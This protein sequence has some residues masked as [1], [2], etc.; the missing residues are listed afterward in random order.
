MQNAKNIKQALAFTVFR[1][2]AGLVVGILLTVFLFIF[3]RGI[4]IISWEFLTAAPKEG[5]LK[6]G[7]VTAIIGTFLLIFYSALIAFPVGI[8][9]GIYMNEYLK[10][11]KVKRFIT[12]I[13][14]N[15][16]GIPSVVFGLF[17]LSIFVNTLGWGVSVISGAFT[18][19]IMILPIVIR[20]TEE[21]LK[22]VEYNF[23]LASY[24][25]G[26]TKWQT[27]WKIVLPTAMPNI[28]TGLILSVGRVAGET[29]PI[30]FTAVAYFLPTI[31]FSID[32]PVMAL[33]YHLYVL[34]TSGINLQASRDVAF[35]TALVLVSLI[36][37]LNLLA[38]FLRKRLKVSSTK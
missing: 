36:F 25:M 11:G 26:A 31:D 5:M 6:G 7:I 34:S 20:T 4:G 16:A 12:I 13:T 2:L 30:I 15:L 1:I 21:S 18:L 3:L 33:P 9:S 19:A 29:A 32:K 35:G 27:I 17:G 24:A 14:N 10:D 28:I 37:I 22:Q 23:R 38:N 8:L